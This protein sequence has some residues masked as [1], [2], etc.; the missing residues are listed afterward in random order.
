[1]KSNRPTAATSRSANS[2]RK[3]LVAGGQ[4]L[5]LT[6]RQQII[7]S[8][9]PNL[10]ISK[11]VVWTP[12]ATIT[13][14]GTEF[15][16]EVYADG[17]AD[18]HV[19]DGIVRVEPINGEK[20]AAKAGIFSA[21]QS[22][23]VVYSSSTG[24]LEIIT[25]ADG[26]R[27]QQFVRSLPSP[28]VCQHQ[29]GATGEFKVAADD[30]IGAGQPTLEKIEL[31]YGEALLSSNPASLND[32]EVYNGLRETNTRATFTP[33]D[34]TVVTIS[35]NTALNP[36]GYD[37]ASIVVLTGSGGHTH[38][39]RRSSQKFDVAY[40]TV[41]E[42]EVFLPLWCDRGA[43]VNRDAYGWWEMQVVLRSVKEIPLARGVAKLRLT[44]HNTNSPH[45][46]SMYREIDIFGSPSGARLNSSPS[47]GPDGIN[48][49]R[50][51]SSETYSN[52]K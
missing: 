43:T 33:S 39:Q 17:H 35:L 37:I 42:P 51:G 6:C 16:V 41:E 48:G 23:R 40:S 11:F 9:S 38:N 12:T 31:T 7:N 26:L 50:Q 28:L 8:Q 30:L 44:F 32:G 49:T 18:F 15:G 4:W 3:W 36:Q 21:G 27:P 29:L 47:E 45:P 20:L 34:G 46:E 5:V 22:G 10:Q 25:V 14:L 19:F 1:M 24:G 13:D 2:L 52:K